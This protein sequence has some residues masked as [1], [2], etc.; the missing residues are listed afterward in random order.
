MQKNTTIFFI[1]KKRPE[2]LIN[3]SKYSYD[4]DESAA[5]FEDDREGEHIGAEAAVAAESSLLPHLQIY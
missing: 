1:L 2:F 3:R 5:R 4:D